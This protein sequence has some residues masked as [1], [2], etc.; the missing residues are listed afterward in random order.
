V[1]R[2]SG[3]STADRPQH[4][5]S[6][7]NAINA[8]SYTGTVRVSDRNQ[9]IN[10]PGASLW[11]H[12][13]AEIEATNNWWGDPSGPRHETGN[14]RGLGGTII[15]SVSFDPWYIDA[16]MTILSN[17]LTL[18][19]DM[20]GLGLVVQ[21]PNE[22]TYNYSDEVTL[23]AL[24]DDNWGFLGWEGDVTGRSSAATLVM[25]GNKTVLAIF[26]SVAPPPPP[27]T[28]APSRRRAKTALTIGDASPPPPTD[29]NPR[30]PDLPDNIFDPGGTLT[31]AQAA[32]VLSHA[33][34]VK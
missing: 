17:A 20:V 23:T 34:D 6:T 12:G 19:I 1:S 16:P 7:F 11:N 15:G 30:H 33:V 21:D 10:I 9:F 27:A 2:R 13:G 3:G 5:S 22:P 24:A 4:G 14:P 31:R 29:G 18:D 8:R 28:L 26:R 32:T 25:D